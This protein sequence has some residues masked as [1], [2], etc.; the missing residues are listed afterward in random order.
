MNQASHQFLAGSGFAFDC[1]GGVGGRDARDFFI[2]LDH[3]RRAADHLAFGQF[4]LFGFLFGI[5][6]RGF[7][8]H[9]RADHHIEVEWLGN[10]I[11]STAARGRYYGFHC[12]APGHEDHR[13]KRILTLGC[14]ENVQ[15]GTLV[16]IDIGDD[17]RVGSVA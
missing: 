2:D 6:A 15:A 3:S 8:A 13:A 14:I 11:E 12:A 1:H 5:V 4:F 16:N 10:V 7:G 9:H 17:D